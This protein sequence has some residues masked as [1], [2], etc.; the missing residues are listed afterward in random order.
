[1]KLFWALVL[2]A[3]LVQA[4]EPLCS[5]PLTLSIAPGPDVQIDLD[6]KV[7]T[8]VTGFWTSTPTIVTRIKLQDTPGSAGLN[9][10]TIVDGDVIS[11]GPAPEG[12]QVL[13]LV[14][15]TGS[16]PRG[17]YLINA[18]NS[19][20][21]Q[22][23]AVT[24]GSVVHVSSGSV[25]ANRYFKLQDDG[26]WVEISGVHQTIMLTWNSCPGYTYQVQSSTNLSL[27]WTPVTPIFTAV[28]A[29]TTRQIFKDGLQMFY[30]VQRFSK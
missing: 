23:V 22:D 19:T 29:L 12:A 6:Y 24:P 14:T 3:S 11:A 17:L 16:L 25:Y 13:V 15:V 9:Q 18:D 27:G 10:T 4:S 5:L 2:T 26:S 7:G 21:W 30:R 8:S 28:E 1:M 20:I